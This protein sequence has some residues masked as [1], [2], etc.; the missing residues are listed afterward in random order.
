MGASKSDFD[1]L[2]QVWRH[3][4][5][6]RTKKLRIFEACV[7]T[8]LIYGLFTAA[9][10]GKQKRRID[11][12]QARCLRKILRIPGAYYS[13]ISNQTVLKIAGYEPLS[14]SVARQQMRYL[15]KIAARND[16][17]PVRN[18][19][20]KAGS[21]ELQGFAGKRRRGRPRTSWLADCYEKFR[22]DAEDV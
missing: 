15:Q 21:S 8:K 1:A 19:V 22:E 3:A 12:F 13:R 16:S 18:F 5:L 7:C 11:G 6:N 14:E 20:F 4:S 9:L 10:T 17:D 2:Q